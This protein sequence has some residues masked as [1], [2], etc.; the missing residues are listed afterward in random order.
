[1]NHVIQ[2]EYSRN[3]VVKKA[4]VTMRGRVQGTG[5]SHYVVVNQA[6]HGGFLSTRCTLLGSL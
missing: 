6:S 5:S 4:V 3:E 2:C 1:M